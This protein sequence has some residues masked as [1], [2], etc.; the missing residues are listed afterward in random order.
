MTDDK[1]SQ[2]W[3]DNKRGLWT[4]IGAGI[5]AAFGVAMHNIAVGVGVG[6]ALGI[7]IGVIVNRRRQ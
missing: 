2:R 4:A 1:R 5:E 6:V 7:A 3:S